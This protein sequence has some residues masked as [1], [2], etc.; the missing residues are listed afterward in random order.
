M[1]AGKLLL[2]GNVKHDWKNYFSKDGF[3]ILGE[4]DAHEID[5]DFNNVGNQRFVW[6]TENESGVLD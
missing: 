1:T 6:Q 3:W 5:S 4:R 2:C